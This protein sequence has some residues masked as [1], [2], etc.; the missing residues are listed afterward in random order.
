M[1]ARRVVS[2]APTDRTSSLRCSH[3]THEAEVSPSIVTSRS[4]R[5]ALV[6]LRVVSLQPYQRTMRATM[7][8]IACRRPRVKLAPAHS[9][10]CQGFV[11]C[12][13][14]LL[15]VI[16]QRV[17]DL[18]SE[19]PQT[20]RARRGDLLKFLERSLWGRL[21]MRMTFLFLFLHAADLHAHASHSTP[22]VSCFKSFR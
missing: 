21:L 4:D 20:K 22:Q 9:P 11:A 12:R 17:L 1:Q 7:A 5:R 14:A 19:G 13:P 16:Q 3:T 18:V 8:C 2:V 15:R 6:L 10:S